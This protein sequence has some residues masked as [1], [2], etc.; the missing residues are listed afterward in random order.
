MVGAG[1]VIT[2][3]VL[4]YALLVGNPARQIGWVSEFGNSLEFDEE[5]LAIC[6]ESGDKYSILD[7]VVVKV[8]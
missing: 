6:R 3:P 7:N 1:A 5:G 2:K 4:P 8:W